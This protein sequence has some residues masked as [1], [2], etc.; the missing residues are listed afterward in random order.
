VSSHTYY[1]RWCRRGHFTYGFSPITKP[2][3]SDC[4]SEFVPACTSCAAPLLDRFVSP[5]F[6]GS[7]AA[8]YPP[9]RP[10]NCTNCGKPFP[11]NSKRQRFLAS[12]RAIPAKVWTEF[13]SLSALHI[14]LL[15]VI[16]FLIIGTITW[17]DLVEILKSLGK[18]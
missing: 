14:T 12:V 11:W 3:C 5:A 18:K 6:F 15:L 9:D 10:E 4:G 8:V 1:C 7:G 2:R 13:K 16:L 17:H